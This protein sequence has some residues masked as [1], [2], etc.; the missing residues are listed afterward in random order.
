[1]VIK[2]TTHSFSLF[3]GQGRRSYSLLCPKDLQRRS[4]RLPGLRGGV[5]LCTYR[6]RAKKAPSCAGINI[7]LNSCRMT[8]YKLR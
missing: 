6:K 8:Q 3:T 4:L 5:V 1:M 7:M 2:T